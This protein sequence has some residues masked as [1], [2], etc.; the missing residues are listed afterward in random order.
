MSDV[1]SKISEDLKQAMREKNQ[2]KVATLR[3]LKTEIVK[4]ETSDKAKELDEK[5]L[6]KL[7]NTMKKQRLEAIEQYEKAERQELADQEKRE[8]VIIEEYLPKQLSAEEIT[9]IVK[10]AISE[11]GASDMKQMGQVMKS[12][13]AKAAGRADG[14]AI[15]AEVRKQLG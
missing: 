10:E 1:R 8:L 7:L 4:Q 2:D 13:V 12:A 15:S 11:V 6:L 9:A 5:G 3:M 14:K